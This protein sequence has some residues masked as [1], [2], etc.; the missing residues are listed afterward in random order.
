MTGYIASQSF[1]LPSEA[2]FITNLALPLTLVKNR[3]IRDFAICELIVAFVYVK[4]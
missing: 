4:S 1:I 2:Y 3:L